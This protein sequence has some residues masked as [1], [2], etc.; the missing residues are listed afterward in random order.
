MVELVG[1]SGGA[2]TQATYEQ[3]GAGTQTAALGFWWTTSA[4]NNGK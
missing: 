3:A 1:T 4:R 2:L